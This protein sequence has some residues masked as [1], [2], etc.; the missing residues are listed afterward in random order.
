MKTQASACVFMRSGPANAWAPR[1]NLKVAATSKNE[2]C[3]TGETGAVSGT[4][5][6]VDVAAGFSPRL[7][8]VRG[9][10]DRR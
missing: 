10:R 5:G 4:E 8:K 7:Y 9:E 2:L 6:P 3:E 1:R